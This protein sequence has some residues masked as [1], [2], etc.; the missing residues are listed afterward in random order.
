MRESVK[1]ARRNS[2]KLTIQRRG[3]RVPGGSQK[4]LSNLSKPL[5]STD[6][7]RLFLCPRYPS[8]AKYWAQSKNPVFRH[9]GCKVER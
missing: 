9:R 4:G 3:L 6:F 8:D 7:Q 5:K 1:S 2:L